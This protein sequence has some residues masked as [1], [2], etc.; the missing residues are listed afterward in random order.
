VR[1][2]SI[3]PRT[4]RATR[5]V[6]AVRYY[7]VWYGYGTEQNRTEQRN[8][9]VTLSLIHETAAIIVPYPYQ[10]QYDTTA[11]HPHYLCLY[12]P[13][14]LTSLPSS[15]CRLLLPTDPVARFHLRNGA[16]FHRLNWMANLSKKGITLPSSPLLSL[17]ICLK[18]LITFEF[19]NH[20]F[21]FLFQGV[22]VFFSSPVLSCLNFF[23]PHCHSLFNK[24]I[25]A[26][27][28]L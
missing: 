25:K 8:G 22:Q 15:V 9:T 5:T 14:F 2:T 6:R 28:I 27:S 4:P 3:A 7:T 10:S 18:G 12:Q 19:N 16:S 17:C 23:L 13:V 11:I 20:Q 21:L 26:W 24:C 1:S